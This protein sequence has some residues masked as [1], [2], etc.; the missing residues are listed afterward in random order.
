MARIEVLDA[1]SWRHPLVDRSTFTLWS[2]PQD[3]RLRC[4]LYDGQDRRLRITLDDG[5]V[6]QQETFHL[7][8]YEISFDETSQ[9]A[10]RRH[11]QGN[12]GSYLEVEVLDDPPARNRAPRSL[13][14]DQAV[15]DDSIQ[16]TADLAD[17]ADRT[18]ACLE[19]LS[20]QPGRFGPP[21]GVMK[22]DRVRSSSETYARSPA[23]KAWILD[24]AGGICECCS[25]D[26]PFVG[27]N[28]RRYLEV[29]HVVRL[30][31]GG[32]DKPENAVA[33]CPNCHR[34]LH[35]AEDADARANALL[36]RVSRLRVE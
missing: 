10:V 30:A 35:H 19:L 18:A 3:L 36:A 8:S 29:H 23:V 28:G 17:L 7:T 24:N 4:G 6:L 33:V 26:G 12:P 9:E 25:E 27:S 13:R 14:L 1:R 2:I 16:P 5:S 31:D 11:R 22:P 20:G 32:A 34:A 15:R 21:K